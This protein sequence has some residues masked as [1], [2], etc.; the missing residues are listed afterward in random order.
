[1]HALIRHLSNVKNS[2]IGHKSETGQPNKKD[3]SELH[4]FTPFLPI[5]GSKFKIPIATEK[6]QLFQHLTNQHLMIQQMAQWWHTQK[7]KIG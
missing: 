4:I 5:L 6:E 2:S 3:S 7:S 1:M